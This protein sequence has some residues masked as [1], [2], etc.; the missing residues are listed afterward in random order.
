MHLLTEFSGTPAEN[1]LKNS[2]YM[3]DRV[4]VNFVM[5]M[6]KTRFCIGDILE[7]YKH[8]SSTSN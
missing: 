5:V 1:I 3:C 2:Q 7:Y 4:L 6:F 8:L